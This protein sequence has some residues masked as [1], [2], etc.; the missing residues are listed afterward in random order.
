MELRSGLLSRSRSAVASWISARFQFERS[1][2]DGDHQT[3]HSILST[4]RWRMEVI[5]SILP[6]V[7]EDPMT[8]VVASSE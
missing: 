7:I 4:S 8:I 3:S 5:D 6:Q 2:G 1:D